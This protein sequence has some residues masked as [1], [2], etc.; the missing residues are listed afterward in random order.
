MAARPAPETV[1]ATAAPVYLTAPAEAVDAPVPEAA[2]ATE[3]L[4][5]DPDPVPL[6]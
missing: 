3:V 6:L 2:P 5:E 4:V 1:L